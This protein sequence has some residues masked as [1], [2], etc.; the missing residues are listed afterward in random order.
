MKCLDKLG[1][2]AGVASHT[3]QCWE[4]EVVHSSHDLDRTSV[5]MSGALAAD[6]KRHPGSVGSV[7]VAVVA[8]RNV[9]CTDSGNIRSARTRHLV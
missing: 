9:G 2:V 5:G 4:S 7:A 6:R 1:W 3:R 8:E